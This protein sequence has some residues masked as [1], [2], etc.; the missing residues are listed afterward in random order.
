M[1]SVA[2]SS[3]KEVAL[4][5][6][7]RVLARIRPQTKK[8]ISIGGVQCV[9][10]NDNAIEVTTEDGPY[11][12]TFDRVFGPESTQAEI[13]EYSCLTLI[14]DVLSGYNA[15]VFACKH[16]VHF[17]YLS[18]TPILFFIFFGTTKRRPNCFR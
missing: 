7:V 16:I 14:G 4:K 1:T 11:T 12:F 6:K 13:Y 3:K 9:K 15:T 18:T 5:E 2:P 17:F 8:E 10:Y